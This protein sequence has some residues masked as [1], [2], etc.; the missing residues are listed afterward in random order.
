MLAEGIRA[1]ARYAIRGA[2]M[3]GKDENFDPDAMVQNFIVGMLGYWTK[4]GL[5]DDRQFNPEVT[6]P[7][8]NADYAD[9]E[10]RVM[11]H[12]VTTQPAPETQE[13]PTL[14][15]MR[16]ASRG[17]ATIGAS[18]LWLEAK[19][20]PHSSIVG[21]GVVFHDKRTGE[22]VAQI[23]VMVPNPKYDYR[24]VAD[25]VIE[26]IIAKFNEVG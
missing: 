6:P 10:R 2:T 1:A 13:L 14:G 18:A 4:D 3:S 17:N 7:L 19:R 12:M 20:I 15:A 25:P 23:A 26:R 9:I 21:S 22:A 8:F 16:N 24:K 5:S 11:A